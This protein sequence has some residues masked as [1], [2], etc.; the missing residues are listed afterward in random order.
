MKGWIQA[1][2]LMERVR[3]YFEF[4]NWPKRE[5]HLSTMQVRALIWQEL[6]AEEERR[7][8]AQENEDEDVEESAQ[9][10]SQN[11]LQGI[12]S[13]EAHMLELCNGSIGAKFFLSHLEAIERGEIDLFL[14]AL[15]DAG[16]YEDDLYDL[17][18]SCCNRDPKRAA[19]AIRLYMDGITDAAKMHE[20]IREKKKINP[21]WIRELWKR[22]QEEE[23]D[24]KKR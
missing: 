18:D 1:E 23:T 14:R 16:I 15:D 8:A 4:N 9:T 2:E 19:D 3:K 22:E 13:R 21:E 6:K 7:T 10:F 5:G 17:W 20:W 11:K 24:G 12:Y